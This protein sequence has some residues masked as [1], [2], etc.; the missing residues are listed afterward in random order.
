METQG[1]NRSI[2]SLKALISDGNTS[3]WLNSASMLATGV[4][5][6][7]ILICNL[8]YNDEGDTWANI[9]LSSVINVSQEEDYSCTTPTA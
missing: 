4:G 5:L 2:E 1:S 7:M 3:H 9:V 6:L 8:L